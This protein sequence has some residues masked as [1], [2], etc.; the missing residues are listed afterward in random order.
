MVNESQIEEILGR[1]PEKIRFPAEP[2]G[3]YDPLRYV[4]AKLGKLV[5]PRLC[6]TAYSLFKETFD[7]GILYPAAA[8]EVFH[9]FTLI[10]DDIMDRADIRR[11]RPT[12]CRKWNDSTAI[13]S[14]DVM[15]IDSFRLMA[16]APQECL[17]RVL[18]LFTRTAAQVCEGQQLDMDYEGLGEIT[19][20]QYME[21]I[22]LKTA[23]LIACAAKVGGIIA[24]ADERT[25]DL[26]YKYGYSLGLAFQIADDYL[27][28]F[29]TEE[30]F[31]KTIGGDIVNNKKTWLL[32]RALEKSGEMEASGA[33]AAEF[34]RSALLET[35]EMATETEN[36]KADKLER[37]REIYEELGVDEDAKYEI[38][39]MHAEAM[40][41]AGL[42]GLGKIRYE[43][44]HRYA[45]R[46]IGRNK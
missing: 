39:R 12:V 36:E 20:E 46:L 41:S 26:L 2:A 40:E 35:M 18:E 44:L 10:H 34:G 1:L 14:G 13:L 7:D 29:G 9:N 31:G 22:G 17:G 38:I 6:L 16:G 30:V 43:V 19:M 45:D 24:G 21:L 42:I 32:T 3:L 23:V 11:G 28:T 25:C 33:V 5:R 4:T 37:M 27:D 8:L 15:S